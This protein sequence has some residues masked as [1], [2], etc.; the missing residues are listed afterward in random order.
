MYLDVESSGGQIDVVDSACIYG[1]KI[2]VVLSPIR[3]ERRMTRKACTSTNL[4][5]GAQAVAN[6]TEGQLNGKRSSNGLTFMFSCHDE[7]SR[8]NAAL[9][10]M[11]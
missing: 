11:K 10:S 3:L 9:Q 7:L 5:V 2:N 6:N 4:I 8:L 1:G